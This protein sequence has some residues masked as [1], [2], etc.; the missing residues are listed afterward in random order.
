MIFEYIDKFIKNKESFVLATILDKS[1]SGPRGK[2]TSMIV[3]K[4]LSII[5]TIGGGTFEAYTI[6]EASEVFKSKENK[7]KHY[8]LENE[9]ASILGMT[10]GGKV[11]VVV[12]YINMEEQEQNKFYDKINQ[13][14][15][16]RTD[17]VLITKLNQHK[18]LNI[19]KWIF[20][21]ENIIGEKTKE[22]EEIYINL[23]KNNINKI[24]F[25]VEGNYFFQPILAEET[26]YIFG[27]G[28]VS[29]KLAKVTKL[30]NFKTV[31]LDDREEFANRKRFKDADEIIVLDDYIKPFKNINIDEQSYIV[32]VTR[33]HLNDKDVLSEALKTR[34]KYIGMIGSR[35]K[36][37]KIFQDLLEEGYTKEDVKR[38]YSPIGLPIGSETPEEIAISIAAELIQIRRNKIE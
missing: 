5:G 8:S 6:K 19:N 31:V 35:T 16:R 14:V 32:I 15:K 18:T 12:E 24:E 36:I 20:T 10:C 29:N 26:I 7:I 37:K 27:A 38:V 2:G 21:K 1:G 34:A 4:D 25:K 28:H 33:G 11:T 3:K 30:I 13:F 23:M 22:I 17:F 9:K